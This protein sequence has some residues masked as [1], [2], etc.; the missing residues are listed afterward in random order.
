MNGTLCVYV[1]YSP[2]DTTKRNSKNEA[3]KKLGVSKNEKR[4]HH[5]Q[6]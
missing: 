3:E 4:K 1:E 5:L 6:S 2:G